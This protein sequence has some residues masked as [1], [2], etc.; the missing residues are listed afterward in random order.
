MTGAASGEAGDGPAE[1]RSIYRSSEIAVPALLLVVA[2]SAGASAA[3]L[4]YAD[5]DQIGP[6]MAVAL[7]GTAAGLLF[8]L[9]S[10]FRRHRWTTGPQGVQVLERP[11][12]PLTGPTRRADIP[13]ADIAQ[14]CEIESGFDRHIEI[15]TRA[16]GRFRISQ[17]MVRQHGERFGRPDPSAP[18]DGFAAMIRAKAARAGHALQAPTQGMGF[19]NTGAGLALLGV[20]FAASLAIAGGVATALLEGFTTR[21]PR[22]GEAIGILLLLPVG[23]GWLWL[24]SWRRRREVL[25]GPDGMRSLPGR[26]GQSPP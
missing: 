23:A 24:K 20:L 7:G 9:M 26:P 5:A 21:Q 13:F 18:L 25:S 22:G 10:A 6:L 1:Y 17:A 15:R 3:I 4:S 2:L 12:I 16:G 11:R 8:V 19:W 14:L